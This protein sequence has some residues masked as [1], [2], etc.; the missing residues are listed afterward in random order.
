[1]AAAKTARLI[2]SLELNADKFARGVKVANAAVDSLSRKTGKIGGIASRGVERLGRNLERLGLI[3]G[4]AAV[5]GVIK[6]TQAAGDFEASLNTINTVAQVLPPQ[7]ADIGDGIRKIARD[8][9]TS[10]DD[11]AAAY[12]DLVSAGIQTADAQNVLTA[13]NTLAI[14]GLST[15]AEAVDLLTTAINSYGGDATQAATFANQFAQAIAAGK[16]TAAEL[17]AS[18]A[19]IGPI[20]ANFGTGVDEIS[21]ALG[22][23][24]AKGTPAAE[25]FTQMRAAIKLL[26]KPT[27]DLKKLQNELGVDFLKI[28]KKKGL[29]FAYNE[30]AKAAKKAG[31]PMTALTG[32][33]EAAQFAAQVTGDEYAKY[34]EELE[35]VRDSSDGA[36]VA[37]EQAA[38][39]MQGFNFAM[40]KLKTNVH[41]AAITIG[42]ELLPEFA[43]LASEATSWLQDHQGEVKAFAKGLASGIRDAVKWIRTLD[44]DKIGAGLS[45]A[46]GF[47]KTLIQAFTSM[48]AEVQATIIALA[49]LNKLSGGAVSGIVSELSKGLIK[50]V[51]GMTAGVVNI[52]AGVVNGA[53]GVTPTPTGPGRLGSVVR[54]GAA[55]TGGVI[56]A[57]AAHEAGKVLATQLAGGNEDLYNKLTKSYENSALLAFGPFEGLRKL[58]GQI[59]QLITV[60]AGGQPARDTGQAAIIEE[61]RRTKQA[62]DTGQAGIIEEQRRTKTA[63]TA[64]LD[65]MRTEAV[66]ARRQA[67]DGFGRTTS[68]VDR[69]RAGIVSAT[70]QG[71]GTVAS[72]VRASRPIVT[73]TV[74]VNV[75]AAKVTASKTIQA[76]YGPGNGSAQQNAR[77][78]G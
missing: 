10:V 27:K 73:T 28:A 13:A 62:F 43:T 21:A 17:A 71:A 51:L 64:G 38:Q 45:A 68:A 70:A 57:E 3:A 29:V 19:T 4:G 33:I 53:G 76:R 48:P 55:V 50:G 49:G 58:P 72:A 67:A 26:E 42:T 77:E 39:R 11:L 18:F 46:A 61:Q 59:D 24:T 75:T 54:T 25:A 44:F 23:M 74:T 69:S 30:M 47:A 20:A 22:V 66:T 8:T 36:G 2:A 7:L 31:I 52:K 63:T 12:Y 1:M 6:A 78:F 37:Q 40:A 16:V 34:T 9:G 14:G 35:R 15:T 65:E 56:V 60:V 5:A 41:D 32:R